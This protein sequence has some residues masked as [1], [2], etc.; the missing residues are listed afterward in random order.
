MAEGQLL[1]FLVA[2]SR[3]AAARVLPR[4]APQHHQGRPRARQHRALRLRREKF[5]R[6][7]AL[8]PLNFHKKSSST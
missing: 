4:E 2:R 7:W 3:G 5:A 1:L 8:L 6:A